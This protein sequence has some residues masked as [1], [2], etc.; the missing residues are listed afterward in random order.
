VLKRGAHRLALKL[1][2]DATQARVL[3]DVKLL[4]PMFELEREATQARIL[5]INATAA[6]S[7]KHDLC[8]SCLMKSAFELKHHSYVC[9]EIHV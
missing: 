5:M 2:R 3:E 4:R 9:L 6:F 7:V 1:K 8:V